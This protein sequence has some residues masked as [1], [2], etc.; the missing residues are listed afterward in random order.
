MFYKLFHSQSFIEGIFLAIFGL[1]IAAIFSK[2]FRHFLQFIRNIIL[3]NLIRLIYP[4][5]NYFGY[6]DFI[7]KSND[8][9]LDYK[10]H[11]LCFNDCQSERE[12]REVMLQLN[13][14]FKSYIRREIINKN[15]RKKIIV[16]KIDDVVQSIKGYKNNELING[17]PDREVFH[18]NY[19]EFNITKFNYKNP[20]IGF[21]INE[22]PEQVN[23]ESFVQRFYDIQQEFIS[24]AIDYLEKEKSNYL[25]IYFGNIFQ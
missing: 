11:L 23:L 19:F 10:N 5:T 16:Q 1:V 7:N 21:S 3:K 17:Y 14:D 18:N 4:K 20:S 13:E 9:F 25:K 6:D 2:D 12:Y 22:L 24:N 8:C 15:I